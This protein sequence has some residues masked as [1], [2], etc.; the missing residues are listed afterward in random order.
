MRGA[1]ERFIALAILSEKLAEK[2]D[3]K[4]ISFDLDIKITWDTS[5]SRQERREIVLNRVSHCE[6]HKQHKNTKNQTKSYQLSQTQK[7]Q[8]HPTSESLG[9]T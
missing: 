4:F 7:F 3:Y 9:H 2:L 1:A 6:K 8:R 5:R